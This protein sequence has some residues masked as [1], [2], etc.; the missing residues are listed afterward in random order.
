MN[1]IFPLTAFAVALVLVAS[2]TGVVQ[3]HGGG[4]AVFF[5]SVPVDACG[6]VGVTAFAPLCV[7]AVPQ[8]FVETRTY[9]AAVPVEAYTVAHFGRAR[10]AGCGAAVNGFGGVQSFGHVRPAG[11]VPAARAFNGGGGVNVQ[12]INDNGRRGFRRR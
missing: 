10:V 4:A 5:R 9:T 2:L 11:F 8:T 6:D 1:R 7:A 12:V 3:A